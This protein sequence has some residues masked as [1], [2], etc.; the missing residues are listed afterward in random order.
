ME[1]I[2][3][4]KSG[5]ESLIEEAALTRV[6][7]SASVLLATLKAMIANSENK[8]GGVIVSNSELAKACNYTPATITK[9]AKVLKET[10]FIGIGKVGRNNCYI[11]NP[12]LL[13]M[14]KY[15]HSTY[16]ELDGVKIIVTGDE[17]ATFKLAVRQMTQHKSKQQRSA[18]GLNSLNIQVSQAMKHKEEVLIDTSTGEVLSK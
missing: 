4:V 13:T 12:D 18:K 14:V 10:G 7:P 9:A 3:F 8:Y 2:S 1:K 15:K 16:T 17:A 5:K 6:Y 11:L